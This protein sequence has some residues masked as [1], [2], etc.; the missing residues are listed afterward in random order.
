M[1]EYAIIEMKYERFDGIMKKQCNVSLN[2]N[3]SI[4]HSLKELKQ[5]AKKNGIHLRRRDGFFGAYTFCL[6]NIFGLSDLWIEVSSIFGKITGFKVHRNADGYRY[7]LITVYESYDEINEHLIDVY[8]TPHFSAGSHDN[9]DTICEWYVDGIT[10][11]HYIFER[12][13]VAD[14]LVF[15]FNNN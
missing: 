12:F 15:D 8:G 7:D 5:I 14:Y 3:F 6:D 10:I 13:A 9:N 4:T 11:R 1:A 2:E